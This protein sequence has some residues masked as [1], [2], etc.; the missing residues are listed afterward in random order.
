MIQ[1]PPW[2]KAMAPVSTQTSS[3]KVRLSSVLGCTPAALLY[4]APIAHGTTLK[5]QS[6]FGV[7]PEAYSHPNPPTHPTWLDLGLICRARS[8]GKRN[9]PHHKG[10][11]R[12]KHAAKHLIAD[13]ADEHHLHKTPGTT[14]YAQ[15]VLS[16]T[17]KVLHLRLNGQGCELLQS[18]LGKCLM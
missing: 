14:G 13:M 16:F 15:S 6:H 5:P 7:N 8:A 10:L 9:P 3:T 4:G 17:G 12:A 2:C 11:Q 18:M 1:G